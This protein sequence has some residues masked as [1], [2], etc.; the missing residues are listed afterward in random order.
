MGGKR[1]SGKQAAPQAPRGSKRKISEVEMNDPDEADVLSWTTEFASAVD[2][3][4]KLIQNKR[5]GTL[6]VVQNLLDPYMQNPVDMPEV[7]KEHKVE[8]KLASLKSAVQGVCT[9]KSKLKEITLENFKDK[10]HEGKTILKAVVAANNFLNKLVEKLRGARARDRQ[11]SANDK[12]KKISEATKT[13]KPLVEGGLPAE[14][15][16]H[17]GHVLEKGQLS[18]VDVANIEQAEHFTQLDESLFDVHVHT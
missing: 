17:L 16:M 9:F 14:L 3:A 2:D 6:M 11:I 8:E 18:L 12:R 15:V 13:F 5:T 10:V 7:Y 1:I 4:L